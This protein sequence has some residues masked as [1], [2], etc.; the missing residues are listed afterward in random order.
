MKNA[1]QTAP[2]EGLVTDFVGPVMPRCCKICSTKKPLED[3]LRNSKSRFGRGSVCKPCDAERARAWRE[4][5]V[6]KSRAT[7]RA[8]YAKDPEAANRRNAQWRA[9]NPD[10]VRAHKKA[11]VDLNR[12]EVSEGL[13]AWRATNP[14]RVK[15]YAQEAKARAAAARASATAFDVPVPGDVLERLRRAKRS[16]YHAA[17]QRENKGRLNE[18]AKARRLTDIEAARARER[19]KAARRRKTDAWNTYMRE[20]RRGIHRKKPSWVSWDQVFAVHAAARQLTAE[21]GVKHEVD[22]IYPRKSGLVCGL[23]VPANLR[24]LPQSANRSKRNRISS[25]VLHE[26][27]SVPAEQVYQEPARA[28]GR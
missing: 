9:S 1:A 24:P 26:M 11:Y 22:H 20:H 3:F 6:E 23:D 10:K 4:Q 18:Q 12:D 8:A 28:P 17:W 7:A 25:S 19:V 2:Q 27:W 13:K 16:A 5:N 15:A 21:T 14:D